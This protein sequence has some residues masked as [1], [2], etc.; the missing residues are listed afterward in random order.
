MNQRDFYIL[1]PSISLLPKLEAIGFRRRYR[2]AVGTGR[3]KSFPV[4]HLTDVVCAGTFTIYL[5]HIYSNNIFATFYRIC[6]FY[7]VASF[8]DNY[9]PQTVSIGLYSLLLRSYGPPSWPRGS[10]QR[11]LVGSLLK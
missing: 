3:F 4:N 11:V 7:T 9:L 10:K 5:P 1:P 2:M 8:F 6:A